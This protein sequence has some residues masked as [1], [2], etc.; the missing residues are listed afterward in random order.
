MVTVLD[1]NP[2][3]KMLTTEERLIEDPVEKA[4]LYYDLRQL[5]KAANLLQ[6]RT[7]SKANHLRMLI[8]RE[9]EDWRTMKDAVGKL[10]ESEHIQSAEVENLL[11]YWQ[12]HNLAGIQTRAPAIKPDNPRYQEAMY[13][14][15]LSWFHSSDSARAIKVW[16]EAIEQDRNSAWACRLDLARG[17]VMLD[18][19]KY[20][21]EQDKIPSLLGRNYMCPNGLDDLAELDQ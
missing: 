15:G 14:L 5:D 4:K 19:S 13:Y 12:I 2:S 3:F 10:S 8:A 7:S 9:Q 21:S 18:P 16:S 20:L 1:E 11:R 6:H 17:L